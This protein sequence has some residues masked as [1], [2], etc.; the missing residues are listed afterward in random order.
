MTLWI[1]SRFVWNLYPTF[2]LIVLLFL[3]LCVR[4]LKSAVFG[5]LHLRRWYRSGR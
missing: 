1:T 3:I 5:M 4:I 2:D